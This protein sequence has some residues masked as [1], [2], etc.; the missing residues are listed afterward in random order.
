MNELD[1]GSA[2]VS[3]DT[4][5]VNRALMGSGNGSSLEGSLMDL[6][7]DEIAERSSARHEGKPLDGYLQNPYDGDADD[8]D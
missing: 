5:K 8:W 2:C 3:N 4:R 1:K 6:E 7:M